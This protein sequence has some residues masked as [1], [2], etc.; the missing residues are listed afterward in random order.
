MNMEK[1]RDIAA[2]CLLGCFII[3][4]IL[5]EIF[6][7]SKPFRFTGYFIGFLIAIFLHYKFKDKKS[8]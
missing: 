7:A 1:K 2:K 3:F 6:A 4:Y 5:T 8:D